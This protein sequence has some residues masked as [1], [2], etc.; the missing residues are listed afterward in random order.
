MM[1]KTALR[2]WLCG[3]LIVA[4]LAFIWGNS[5][6]PGEDS[7]ELSGFVGTLLQTI[8]PFLDLNSEEGMHLL[9]K[10]AHFTEFAALGMSFT[11]LWSMLISA[12]LPR[13]TLPFLCGTLAA[14]I[15]ETIQLFSPDRG[16]SIKD[17]ILDS[18]GVLFG[19][20]A[21]TCLCH[22]LQK[23]RTVC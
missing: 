6:L 16:P 7:G 4:L 12:R 5:L 20:L 15:D 19:V 1:K 11:W 21:I 17:V 22:L 23:N 14:A 18:S 13:M 8:L 9:R 2:L 10:T 3:A